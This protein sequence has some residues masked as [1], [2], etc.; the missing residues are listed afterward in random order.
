MPTREVDQLIDQLVQLGED[1]EELEFYRDIFD[2]MEEPEQN[3]ILTNLRQE[4]KDLLA[5]A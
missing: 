4:I 5:A 1:K 3:E 2:N